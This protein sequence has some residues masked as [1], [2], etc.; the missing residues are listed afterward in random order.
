MAAAVVQDEGVPITRLDNE[1]GPDDV[2]AAV[3]RDGAVIVEGVAERRCWTGSRR[4][5][6]PSSRP[7]RP[8][9]DDFS[10]N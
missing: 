6:G 2:A 7:R 8:G 10:G 5:C 3:V 9:P 4:S 1:A